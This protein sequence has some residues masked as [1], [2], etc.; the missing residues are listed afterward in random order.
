ML[1]LVMIHYCMAST[2]GLKK[3]QPTA[4]PSDIKRYFV[5]PQELL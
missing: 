1:L 4:A 5:T 2:K 3:R